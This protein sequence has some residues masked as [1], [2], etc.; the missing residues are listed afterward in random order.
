[1]EYYSKIKKKKNELWHVQQSGTYLKGITLNE[2]TQT[3]EFTY[4]LISFTYYSQNSKI[5][6]ME[7]KS[8]VARS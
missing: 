1:M 3:P 8:E 4:Y 7:N 6:V 2:K 5:T